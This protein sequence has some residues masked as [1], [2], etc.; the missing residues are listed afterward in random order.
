MSDLD[1]EEL[2]EEREDDLGVRAPGREGLPGC[3]RRAAPRRPV[4]RVGKPEASPSAP[5]GPA[6]D[7]D[8]Q[9]LRP[10]SRW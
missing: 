10:G 3:A 5:G 1:S 2:E 4:P 7:E 8:E 9:P 6:R